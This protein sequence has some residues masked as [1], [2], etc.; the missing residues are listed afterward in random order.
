MGLWYS[1]QAIFYPP[2]QLTEAAIRTKSQLL[3]IRIRKIKYDMQQR[4]FQE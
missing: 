2:H 1:I 4:T 3:T